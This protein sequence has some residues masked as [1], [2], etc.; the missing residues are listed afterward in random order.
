MKKMRRVMRSLLTFLV[1]AVVTFSMLPTVS[2]ADEQENSYTAITA[3]DFLKADGRN[4]RNA[5][6]AGEIVNLRGTNAGGLFVQEFWMT[7]T[8]D[9]ANVHDQ[10]GIMEKL[11]ERFGEEAMFALVDAYEDAYWKEEDFR[12]VKD[13]GLNVIRLPFW[14]RNLTDANGNFYGYDENAADPYAYAFRKLDWFVNT[15]GQYGLYVILDFHG[16]PGSQNGSD[17]SGVDG[18]NSKEAAS[19]FFFGDN[20]PANQQLY[21]NMLDVIA[22]RYAGNPVVAGYDIMNEPFCTYVRDEFHEMLWNIYDTAYDRIRAV[23]PDHVIIMEAVWNADALPAPGRY[24]WENVMYEYHQYNYGDYDNEAGTQVS[25]MQG[26]L[27]NIKN[28]DYDVP[29]YIG[30][31]SLF[32]SPDAWNTALQIMTESGVNWTTWTY[33]TINGYGMWGL[34]HHPAD[35][36]NG[37]NVETASYE[38]ILERWQRSGTEEGSENTALTQVVSQWAA[39]PTYANTLGASSIELEN[40]EYYL[41]VNNT[42]DL[43]SV[44]DNM[45]YA[46]ETSSVT[47][48]EKFTIEN[49]GGNAY[50]KSAATGKY[51]KV[52]SDRSIDATADDTSAATAFLI[53]NYTVSTVTLKSKDNGL[54]IEEGEKNGLVHASGDQLRGMQTFQLYRADNNKL[55]NQA[56]IDEARKAF[57]RYEAEDMEHHGGNVENQGFY[58]G[59]AA[60]GSLNIG[61]ITVNDVSSD[62]SNINYVK[63]N[64]NVAAAGTYQIVVHYNGDDDKVYLAK[65]NDGSN[66]TINSRA[67]EENHAWDHMHTNLV[68]LSLNAGSNDVYISGALG[69]GWN[70]IDCIDVIKTPLKTQTSGALRY[71]GENFFATGYEISGGSHYSG[72]KAQ[73]GFNQDID[74]TQFAEDW[75]NVRFTEYSV[76][77][78]E[79]GE[80]T[81]TLGYDGNNSSN[82]KCMYKVND[83]ENTELTISASGWSSSQTKRFD[84]NLQE[85]INTIKISGTIEN[86]SDW[87]NNDYID[88][89]KKGSERVPA[90][91][92]FTRLEGED[93]A[94][95]TRNGSSAGYERQNF[96]SG[97]LAI[98]NLS[99]GDIHVSDV[100][101]DWSNIGYATFTVNAPYAGDYRVILYYNGDDDKESLV[102]VNGEVE[103]LS[104]PRIAGGQWDAYLEKVFTVHLNEGNNELSMTGAIG[105]GWM[106]I[107]CIDVASYPVII[108]EDGSE[109]YEAENFNT[110]S[111]NN[112]VTEHQDF[113][114]GH[115]NLNGVGGM[116]ATY[117]DYEYGQD[118]LGT[119]MNYTDYSIFAAMEGYY[120][121]KVA[122]N[123]AGNDLTCVYSVNGDSTKTFRLLNNGFGWDHMVYETIK[124]YLNK[125][126]NDLLLAGTYTGSWLNYDY[127]DVKYSEDQTAPDEEE[128]PEPE[129]RDPYLTDAGYT[130]YEAEYGELKDCTPETQGMYSG[131]RNL[132]IGGVAGTDNNFMLGDDIKGTALHYVIY[133]VEVE[134]AGTYEM[135][136]CGNGADKLMPIAYQINGAPSEGLDFDNTLEGYSWDRMLSVSAEIEL[137]EGTNEVIVSGTYEY[138][139]GA[140]LNYDYMDIKLI[141]EAEEETPVED[142]NQNGAAPSSGDAGSTSG[143]TL[144]GSSEAA[145]QVTIINP[146][147]TTP[148]AVPGRI[149]NVLPTVVPEAVMETDFESAANDD[150]DEADLES[151]EPEEEEKENINLFDDETPQAV[152][153]TETK[154]SIIPLALTLVVLL[155]LAAAG[156]LYFVKRNK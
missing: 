67:K 12:R 148:V 93:D 46:K 111:S 44:S 96:Y 57:V 13:L 53:N 133:N 141:S 143:N 79:A 66:V 1:A 34:Y 126:Y 51:L 23:D 135:V 106:N 129:N 11:T 61:D 85:G 21:Y 27:N 122:G 15:A 29:S 132:G 78:E 62:W 52:L 152:M 64:V 110:K 95:L 145:P 71:E 121:I 109:R 120:D 115:A 33:K 73:G 50:L 150:E 144:G 112:P 20:A 32:N 7:P 86:T 75:I 146:L 113:Y 116:G 19:E 124:V 90:K 59:G 80:Y 89:I 117:T 2:F 16:L 87:A 49:V 154:K 134:K 55:Y 45:L 18:G 118:I 26:K 69:G 43:L 94:V 142:N 140:W 105:G 76:Y 83:G 47:D 82:M 24:G 6:G 136:I 156:S 155:S 39:A 101:S 68:T 56:E 127:I 147:A 4:L 31:F 128:G 84:V 25:S 5:S 28:A 125:G 41:S 60:I 10:T 131:S 8:G 100:A 77:A 137:A 38:E 130:R 97:Q 153:K 30:E 36:D 104:I 74:R 14:W 58:S 151:A 107:D 102:R 91:S 99:N 98:G 138:I 103:T 22:A 65:A 114:S 108:N 54:L 3:N 123:G 92:G 9:S 48:A 88:V 42:G 72:S 70:N 35:M 119:A 63:F 17:H 139:D 149:N 40:T 81:I 37:I